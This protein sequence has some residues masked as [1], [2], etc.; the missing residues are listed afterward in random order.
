[1]T[2]PALLVVSARA[3][4][5]A[6]V[7]ADCGFDL[8]VCEA[9]SAMSKPHEFKRHS[10]TQYDKAGRVFTVMPAVGNASAAK[11][12]VDA[13]LVVNN[14][15]AAHG[16]PLSRIREWVRRKAAKVDPKANVAQRLKRL[17]SVRAKNGRR[18][19]GKVP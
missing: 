6:A 4:S 19:S 13:V 18:W 10:L 17:A 14:W 12:W 3:E 9:E 11:A 8:C 15:R 1:M 5:G 2:N 16:Y 7:C